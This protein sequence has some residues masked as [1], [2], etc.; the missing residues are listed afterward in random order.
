[1]PSRCGYEFVRP[2]GLRYSADLM[3]DQIFALD[4]DKLVQG[5]L[6]RLDDSLMAR[7]D[8]AIREILGLSG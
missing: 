5:P 6:A 1:M 3:I 4:T 8:D 2:A 7:V